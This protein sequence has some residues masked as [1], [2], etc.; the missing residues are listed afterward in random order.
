M[1]G[2]PGS[3]TYLVDSIELRAILN[4]IVEIGT[5]DL[6]GFVKLQPPT[7]SLG[8][9]VNTSTD[10]LVE[11]QEASDILKLITFQDDSNTGTTT[12]TATGTATNNNNAIFTNQSCSVALL[13]ACLCNL[14]SFRLLQMKLQV[15][16]QLLMREICIDKNY[17]LLLSLFI[18]L[19]FYYY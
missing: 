1:T 18:F 8:S 14:S 2:A 12:G 15:R 16:L 5:L 11:L 4:K 7:G 19:R 13:K 6:V 9:L 10:V 17:L 3:N